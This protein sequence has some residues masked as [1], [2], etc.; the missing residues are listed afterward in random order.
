VAALFALHPLRVES[1]AWT[2]KR[3]DVLSIF[4]GEEILLLWARNFYVQE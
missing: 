1:V 3:K 4:F 2:P